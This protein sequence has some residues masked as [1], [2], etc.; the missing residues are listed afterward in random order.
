MN[1]FW[2]PWAA[3]LS[4]LSPAVALAA[5]AVVGYLAGRHGR[6]VK[7]AGDK[8]T[9]REIL[10]TLDSVVQLESIT[11]GMLRAT[12]DASTKCRQSRDRIERTI[13][14]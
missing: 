5:V 11:D 2:F 1:D 13:S 10:R 6:K 4:G 3:S 12:R 8:A 9:H 14:A 7:D